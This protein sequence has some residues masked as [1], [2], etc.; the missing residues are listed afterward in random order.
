MASIV[1]VANRALTKL[2]A[3]RIASLLDDNK[4]ARSINSCIDILLRAELRTNRWTFAIKRVELAADIYGP[5]FGY[6]YSYTLPTDMLRLDMINDMDPA[7]P[8]DN[9]ISQEILDY[10]IEGNKILTDLT[11][12]LK[13]RYGSYV[14]DPNQWD[15]LFVEAF[16][17]RLAAEICEDIT[18]S[19][20]KRDRAWSEYKA[21]MSQAKKVN[22]IE[23]P[24]VTLPDDNWIFAR[25]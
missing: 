21:A 19:N 17:C 20:P 15:E 3:A 2:G 12:P 16:A 18:Q 23:R 14:G 10:E 25:L 24:P 13:V 4:Q 22:A 8:L 11:A 6:T 7:V 1:D 5:T 9:Y